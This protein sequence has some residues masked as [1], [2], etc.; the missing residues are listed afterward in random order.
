MDNDD[1]APPA[2]KRQK[3]A[4]PRARRT[5]KK[6]T[7]ETRASRVLRQLELAGREDLPPETVAVFN[8]R[9][10]DLPKEMHLELARFL[11]YN[12][13]FNGARYLRAL[14]HLD[15]PERLVEGYLA[16]FER[17]LWYLA[18]KMNLVRSKGVTLSRVVLAKGNKFSHIN[19]LPAALSASP[20]RTG[21]SRASSS[22]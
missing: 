21:R 19:L 1:G 8:N 11:R 18:R 3:P 14:C 6:T 4:A 15:A 7:E 10:L 2:A 17:E 22:K 20:P 9:L 12:S 5:N 13:L 16:G